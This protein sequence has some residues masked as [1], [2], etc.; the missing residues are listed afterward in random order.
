MLH[1]SVSIAIVVLLGSHIAYAQQST[2]LE[3]KV[4][5]AHPGPINP[6][7]SI[8]LVIAQE[9]GLFGKRGLEARIVGGTIGSDRLIGKEAEFGSFGTP[10]VLLAIARR[11]A[12]LKILGV[13]NTGKTT[14]HLVAKASIKTPEELRGKRFGL[15]SI[16]A[17]TWI[18]TIQALEHL[19]LEAGRDQIAIVEVGNV[20][21]MAKALED[22]TIDA[23]MLTPAQ[24]G[25][26]KAK[27]YTVLLDMQ[28]TDIYGAPRSLV[29]TSAFLQEH[30]DIVEKVVAAFVEA[31]AFALAPENKSTVLVTIS[32]LF[33]L[34]QPAA[35]EKAYEELRNL[36]RKPYASVE[37]LKDMQRIMAL[38]EPKVMGVKIEDVIDDRVVRKLDENGTIDQL[39]SSYGVK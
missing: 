10:A 13:I 2:A 32:K 5:I 28:E 11:Q 3:K 6:S 36:N 9:Q 37:R 39:Y 1:K 23:A 18:T 15:T 29:T 8:P 22:G 35:A 17:G 12:D 26:L 4:A 30:P 19:G 34:T 31:M 27:G 33:G 20:T 14:E 21:Q 24:S 38:H 25:E 7:A 16:G